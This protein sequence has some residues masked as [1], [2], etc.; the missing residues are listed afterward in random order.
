MLK[1]KRK[2]ASL[3]AVLSFC[4]VSVATAETYKSYSY[5]DLSSAKGIDE[6]SNVIPLLSTDR[7]TMTIQALM[8]QKKLSSA[9][10]IKSIREVN[11]TGDGNKKLEKIM[12]MKISDAEKQKAVEKL[13]DEEEKMPNIVVEIEDAHSGRCRLLQAKVESGYM[14]ENGNSAEQLNTS[15]KFVKGFQRCK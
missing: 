13:M 3:I 5:Q 11:T 8:L 10:I 12:K 4:F 6:E 9:E 14:D 7:M 2:K 1:F 15:V